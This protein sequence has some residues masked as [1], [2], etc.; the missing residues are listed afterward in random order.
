LENGSW[1][2]LTEIP[3]VEPGQS[4]TTV[5]MIPKKYLNSA[6]VAKLKVQVAGKSLF[7]EIEV[8][9]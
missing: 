7:Q 3:S 8:R 9:K 1:A 6:G 5:V 2:V 4:R